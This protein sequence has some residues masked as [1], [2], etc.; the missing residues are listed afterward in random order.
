MGT[1]LPSGIDILLPDPLVEGRPIQYLTRP[2]AMGATIRSIEIDSDLVAMQAPCWTSSSTP[3]KHHCLLA[4]DGSQLAPEILLAAEASCIRMADRVDILLVNSP[5]MP[6]SI[7][8]TLLIGLEQAGID[9]RLSSAVG[10][11]GEQITRHLRRFLGIKQVLVT[12]LS[13]LELAG[14]RLR[15]TSLSGLAAAA[16]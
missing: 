1:A 6:I 4:L 2:L 15:P 10:E 14:A 16:T 12:S 8:H 11:M 7:L 3:A 13:G 5:A 9:Y